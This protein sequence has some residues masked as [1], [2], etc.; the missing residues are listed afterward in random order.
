MSNS[1]VQALHPINCEKLM[2]HFCDRNPRPPTDMTLAQ[3]VAASRPPRLLPP[4]LSDDHDERLWHRWFCVYP[5]VVT[6]QC[7]WHG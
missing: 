7:H 6:A 2:I 3:P 1:F 4:W 5:L